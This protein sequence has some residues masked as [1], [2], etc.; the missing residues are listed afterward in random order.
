MRIIG[1][2][3][4][5]E[6]SGI[7]ILDDGDKEHPIRLHDIK[8][9]GSLRCFLGMKN[10]RWKEEHDYILAIETVASY[11]MPVGKSIF[12]TCIWIG[13]FIEAWGSF[14]CLVTRPQ[15][16]EFICH[17]TKAGDS[18]VRQALIDRYGEPGVKKDPGPTHGVVKD[19]WSALA[20]ATTAAFRPVLC[21]PFTTNPDEFY[22]G[23]G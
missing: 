9:N 15:V 16:T 19:E 11:G 23:G 22:S 21:K 2:D 8:G 20:V 13:R 5:P 3:P 6:Q 12:V 10:P 18:H 7:V 1:I 4:A 17:S 14:Y